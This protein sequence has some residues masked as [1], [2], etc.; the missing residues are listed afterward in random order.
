MLISYQ[1]EEK[2]RRFDHVNDAPPALPQRSSMS[3][4]A[5]SLADVPS[6]VTD[7]QSPQSTDVPSGPNSTVEELTHTMSTEKTLG[8]LAE[9]TIADDE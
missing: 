9:L 5:E 3:S 7:A 4:T 2:L 1:M 8:T 6:L